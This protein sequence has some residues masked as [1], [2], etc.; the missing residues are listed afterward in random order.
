MAQSRFAALGFVLAGVLFLIGGVLPYLRGGNLNP[1][2]VAVGAAFLVLG[3]GLARKGHPIDAGSVT[4]RKVVP[5]VDNH[6]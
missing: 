6:E 5:P 4:A 1:A 2:F 3:A